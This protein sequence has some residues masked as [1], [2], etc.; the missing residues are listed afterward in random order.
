MTRREIITTVLDHF[1]DFES[2]NVNR[3]DYSFGEF[4]G[5]LNSKAGTDPVEMRKISGEKADSLPV[6]TSKTLSDISILLVLMYRYARGYIKQAMKESPL[7]TPDEFSFLITLMTCKSMRKS[8][9]I[10]RQV[11]EKTSGTEVIKRLINKGMITERSDISDR[12]GKML[13]ITPA[14][15]EEIL[16]ILPA[17][18][19]VS[20]IIAGNLSDVE[21]NT[22]SYLL[23]KLDHFHNDIYLSKKEL[24]LD[25]I[26]LMIGKG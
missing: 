6:Y 7:H 3:E 25:E 2:Q 5:Y 19:N 23:R 1:F 16:R 20:E 18:G 4:I 11:M 14:G 24:S 26:L 9:L 10:S 22:L 12:R 8:E 13:S 21:I 15:S 17:M